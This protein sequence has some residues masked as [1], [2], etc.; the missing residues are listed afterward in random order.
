M[1]GYDSEPAEFNN[2]F[3]QSH[4][5]YTQVLKIWIAALSNHKA[6]SLSS[7]PSPCICTN[8]AHKIHKTLQHLDDLKL[9][10]NVFLSKR[11]Q[12]YRPTLTFE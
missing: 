7:I 1:R 2:S 12:L 6:V 11:S 10:N 3:W 8:H 9:S 5:P 4:F